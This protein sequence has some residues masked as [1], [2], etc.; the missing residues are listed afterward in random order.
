MN[1]CEMIKVRCKHYNKK[2]GC[3]LDDYTKFDCDNDIFLS[4]DYS[5]SVDWVKFLLHKEHLI[6]IKD[7]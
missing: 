6:E 2:N 5:Q 4:C 7:E 3:G 1:D